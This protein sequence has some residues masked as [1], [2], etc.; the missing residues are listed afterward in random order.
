MSK[1]DEIL[2]AAMSCF[3]M[4]GC[5]KTTMRDIGNRVGINKATLC[6]HFKDKL[7]L[8]EAV[9][10]KLRSSHELNVKPQIESFTNIRDK[11]ICLVTNYID[12]WGNIAINYLTSR[13]SFEEGKQETAPV[14]EFRI[15]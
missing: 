6:Y 13:S 8:Y 15:L 12:F 5:S 9:V 3:S 14:F 7:A 1:S 10:L 2:K 4:Y 11:I